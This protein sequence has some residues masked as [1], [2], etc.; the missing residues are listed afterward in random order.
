MMASR[1][2]YA[3]AVVAFTAFGWVSAALAEDTVT[4]ASWGGTY[5]EA[6]NKAFFEP[7]AKALGIT[8]RQDNVTQGLPDVRL[9]VE[10]GAVKWDLAV[11][12]IEECFR[13]ETEGLFERLDPSIVKTD[14]IDPKLKGDSWVAISLYAI[15]IAYNT[16]GGLKEGGPQNWAEF[17]DTKKFPGPRS[18][19]STP[20]ETLTAAA[21]ADG[22]APDKLYPFDLDRAFR[23][24]A[25]I[26]P[27]V[28]AWWSSGSQI[29]NLIKD[30]NVDAASIYD[31]RA[32]TL[33][34]AGAPI[35]YTFNQGIING[36]C[37]VIPKGAKN[38]AGAMKM[39]G[40]FVSPELQ[41]NVARYST[42]APAN[43]KGFDPALVNPDDAKRM[44]F[45]PE[46]A[47]R[48]ITS[49]F[50]WWAA[51]QAVV[52]QRWQEFLQSK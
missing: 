43:S 25:E 2:H 38:K 13:G 29:V 23:K 7:A 4:I 15:V 30:D 11:I 24:L 8:V 32:N 47:R 50:R 20:S 5:Q 31:G 9:Q 21:L 48:M 10:G 33:V 12:G 52:Q 3:W 42:N 16:A 14:G 41:A 19:G 27:S 34:K 22:V 18:L 40:M 1:T 6:Q 26:K 17:W 44:I 45:Y 51:N 39:L 49:D 36:D 37:M 46:N 28:D 35:S